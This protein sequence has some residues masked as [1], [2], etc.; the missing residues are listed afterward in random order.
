M[1]AWSQG[2][3]SE[4]DHDEIGNICFMAL[5]KTSDVR[6]FNFLNCNYLQD[7]LD[8]VIGELQKVFDKYNKIAQEKKGW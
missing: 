4:D 2:E 5:G 1:E 6:S 8:M 3:T 7:S